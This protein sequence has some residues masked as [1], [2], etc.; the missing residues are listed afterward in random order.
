MTM[1]KI[2]VADAD[3]LSGLINE[4]HQLMVKMAGHMGSGVKTA[5]DR[6]AAERDERRL[7]QVRAKISEL[8]RKKDGGVG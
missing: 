4:E 3:Q 8:D 5:E 1:E 6:S 7:V 2:G